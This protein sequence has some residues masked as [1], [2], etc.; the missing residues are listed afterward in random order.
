M[1]SGAFRLDQL[2][3]YCFLPI[4]LYVNRVII[5]IEQVYNTR[6]SFFDGRNFD[7]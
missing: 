2:L 3:T 7:Q 1:F 5:Q 4:D 6:E